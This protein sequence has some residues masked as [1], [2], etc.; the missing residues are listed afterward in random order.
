M[1]ETR[2]KRP[3]V[4][5]TR[6]LPEPVEARMREL[7]DVTISPDDRQMSGDEI[8]AAAKDVDV[9]VPTVTDDIGA[10][11]IDALA[12][13]KLIANFGVGVDHINLDAAAKRGVI[14]TNTPGVLTEDTADMTLA[15]L[16]STVRRMRVGSQRLRKGEWSGWSP[17]AMRGTRIGGK[18]L[19]IVGMGRIGSAVARRAQAF[20]MAVH[21]SNRHRMPEAVENMLGATWWDDLDAMLADVDVV[22]IHCP[23][24]AETDGLFDAARLR[25][26]KEGAYLIN[27]A[28]GEIVDETALIAALADG[29]LA[30][31]GLDVFADEPNVPQALL[32]M[33]QVTLLPHM[34]SA[35]FEGR[36]AMGAKVITNI[37]VWSDGHRPP[38]QVL[39]GF[40]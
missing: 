24:T 10:D 33:H 34:G 37:R 1:S 15:L 5:V 38:D 18:A 25:R 39:E 6:H 14:V 28:R 12:D 16:L 8:A 21:Y 36:Q 2:P 26:M 19:G 7:F 35:T 32:D 4:F 17:T 11:V 3:T 40:D 31:A 23:L 20:G 13:L 29:H 27:T 30:G 9:L 22:S